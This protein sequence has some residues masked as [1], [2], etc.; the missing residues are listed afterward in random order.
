MNQTSE[1]VLNTFQQSC[2]EYDKLF[3]PEARQ[4]SIVESLVRLYE[5]NYSVELLVETVKYYVRHSEEEAL[6]IYD[7]ALI[8][9][10]IRERVE[11]AMADRNEIAKL[12]RETQERMKNFEL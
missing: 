11:E 4:D 5:K 7:F 8:Q 2:E 1:T 3:I 6:R 9:G 10:K 12:M